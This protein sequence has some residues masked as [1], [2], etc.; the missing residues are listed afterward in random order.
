M[1]VAATATRAWSPR[2]ARAGRLELPADAVAELN[3]IAG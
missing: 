1:V 3:A 2:S